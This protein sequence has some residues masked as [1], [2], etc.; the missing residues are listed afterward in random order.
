[1]Q[2]NKQ[3]TTISTLTLEHPDFEDQGFRSFLYS[4][5]CSNKKEL[6]SFIGSTFSEHYDAELL[7]FYPYLFG[8]YDEF[9]KPYAAVGYRIAAEQRLFLEQ[10]LDKPIEEYLSDLY[11]C[12]PQVSL[13]PQLNREHIIEIGNLAASKP[14]ACRKLFQLLTQYF[15]SSNYKWIVF[16]GTRTVRVVLKR[17]RLRAYPIAPASLK[18]IE[19]SK[20]KSWGSY[21]DQEPMVMVMPINQTLPSTFDKFS[22]KTDTA[23]S[24]VSLPKV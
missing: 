11:S 22:M 18:D 12:S 8:A 20:Q 14:G 1:M 15:C 13:N 2:N 21:Y 9:N 7:H 6:E 5:N 17:M 24:S 19:A 4:N 16:T 10:Y 23:T 3:Q